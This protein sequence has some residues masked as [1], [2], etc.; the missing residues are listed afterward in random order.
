M[1]ENLNNL[2]GAKWLQYSFSIWRD[3]EKKS[4]EKTLGHPAMFPITLAEKIIDIFTNSPRQVVL[5][6]FMGSGTT[7]IAAQKKGVQSIGFEINTSYVSMAKKRLHTVYSSKSSTKENYKIIN[8]SLENIDKY[9][10]PESIDLTITSP[11][12]WD[13][14]T[15]NRTADKKSIRNYGHL[16]NDFGI[17]SDYQLF[18]TSLHNAFRKVYSVTKVGRYCIVIVMDIRKK[19]NFILF[20]LM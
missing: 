4:E 2:G 17:I 11:P 5:D 18:L 9:L 15:R 19:I 14:L 1:V 10:K 7:V 6:P 8:D 3:I 16:K 12:Y 20:I 13:I